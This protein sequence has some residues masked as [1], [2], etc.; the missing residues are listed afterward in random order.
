[1]KLPISLIIASGYSTYACLQEG[2]CRGLLG[3]VQV[4]ASGYWQDIDLEGYSC[5]GG[6]VLPDTLLYRSDSASVIVGLPVQTT[7]QSGDGQ[8]SAMIEATLQVP[9]SSNID[10]APLTVGS[11]IEATLAAT[12]APV[13]PISVPHQKPV[14]EKGDVGFWYCLGEKP[15]TRNDRAFTSSYTLGGT[16]ASVYYPEQPLFRCNIQPP[17]SNYFVA[18]WTR[19]V[20]VQGSQPQPKNCNEWLALENP[21]NGRT[22]TALVIDRCA[23]CVGVGH[24]MSDSYVP[25]SVVNGATIDL[26]PDLFHFL[27]EDAPDGVYDITYNGSVYGGSWDGNPDDLKNPYCNASD[28]HHRR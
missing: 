24:Q 2:Q 26:S 23:S 28:V 5:K 18:V 10:S 3:R 22:A 25:D 19:Y 20:P 21:K 4:C 12:G 11:S 8:P 14:S 15:P 9:T 1:M 7:R 6:V 17:T 27:Y 16:M 13:P